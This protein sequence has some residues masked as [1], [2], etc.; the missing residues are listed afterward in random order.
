MFGRD[1]NLRGRRGSIADYDN[2][3]YSPFGFFPAIKGSNFAVDNIALCKE[4]AV[5][6]ILRKRN[7][8]KLSVYIPVEVVAYFIAVFVK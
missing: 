1:C 3:T 8:K 2:I 5:K 4:S 6:C 7:L